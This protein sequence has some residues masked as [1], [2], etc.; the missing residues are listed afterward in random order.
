MSIKEWYR[1]WCG[2]FA[3]V[4]PFSKGKVFKEFPMQPAADQIYYISFNYKTQPKVTVN[5]TLNLKHN[6]TLENE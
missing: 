2:N 3:K 1:L 4:F 5:L 6:K